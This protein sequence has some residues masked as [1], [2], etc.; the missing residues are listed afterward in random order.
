MSHIAPTIGEPCRAE[1]LIEHMRSDFLLWVRPF[2]GMSLPGFSIHLARFQSPVCLSGDFLRLIW[3]L[4]TPAQ[5]PCMLPHKALPKD[6]PPVGQAS[7]DKNVNF[8]CATAP[9]TVSPAPRALT[10]CAALPRDSALYAVS[11]RRPTFL[12]LGFL[13]T[14]PRGNALAIG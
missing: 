8:P 1:C 9:F 10:C 13:Q 6:R 7:P 4:L 11:V 5:T 14:P 3:P 2:S 12:H